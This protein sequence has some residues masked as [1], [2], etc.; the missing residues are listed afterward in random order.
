MSDYERKVLEVIEN[1][2][3]PLSIEAVRV[4]AGIKSWVT[5]KA[6]LLELLAKGKLVGIK[7]D[8]SW[9][10]GLLEKMKPVKASPIAR[11]KQAKQQSSHRRE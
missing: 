1:A 8:K 2:E 10:F 5:A 6:V 3:T 11:G 4:K 7:T 9:S